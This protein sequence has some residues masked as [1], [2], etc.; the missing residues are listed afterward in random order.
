MSAFARHLTKSAFLTPTFIT[1]SAWAG[2]VPF[3]FWLIEV[4]RPQTFVELGTFNGLSFMAFCQSIEANRI[5]AR[6]Y[7][8]DTWQGDEH[9]GRIDSDVY[10]GLK[11]YVADKYPGIATLIRAAFA[12]AVDT[13]EDGSIDL[14]HIDG[15]HSYE[16][17]SSDFHTWKSKLTSNAVVLFHD[18][19][20]FEKGYEVHRFWQEVRQ[21]YR[22]FEFEHG[23]GLGVLGVGSR[24]PPALE[25]LFAA[26]TED[27]AFA[28]AAFSRLGKSVALSVENFRLRRLVRAREDA[29]A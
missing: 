18:T 24:F 12:Q 19:R 10:E 26:D 28:R 29:T 23:F 6:A 21:G 14:L 20:V 13:F 8:I 2:H 11:T 3:A 5:P 27:A 16:A 17:V 9:A 22:S 7:A 25:A 1:A 15:F 4:L